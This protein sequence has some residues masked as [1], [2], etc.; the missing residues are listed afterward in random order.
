MNSYQQN[1]QRNERNMRRSDRFF[2]AMLVATMILL[3]I[4]GVL[5][6]VLR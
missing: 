2:K 5:E 6:L 3:A 1:R 4:F